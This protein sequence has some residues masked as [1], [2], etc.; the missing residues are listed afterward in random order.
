MDPDGNGTVT[1]VGD[2]QADH[3]YWGRPEQQTGPRPVKRE[4]TADTLAN[5]ATILTA[6]SMILSKPG[7]W[8]D[9]ALAANYLTRAR[10]LVA[11][12]DANPRLYADSAGAYV[13]SVSGGPRPAALPCR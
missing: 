13:S 8:A 4:R 7:A 12:A 1:Q 3:A 9:A 6:A 5:S 10:R 2:T 11:V